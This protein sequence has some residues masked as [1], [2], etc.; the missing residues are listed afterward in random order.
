MYDP[1][2]SLCYWDSTLEPSDMTT[3]AAWTSSLFGNNQGSVQTG[4]AAG[5]NTPLGVL[6]RNGGQVGRPFTQQVA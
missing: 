1:T 4:F 3:S 5:W 6:T 2:L